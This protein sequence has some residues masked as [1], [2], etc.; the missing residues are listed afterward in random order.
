MRCD[1]VSKWLIWRA[2]QRLIYKKAW[3]VKHKNVYGMYIAI[4][5]N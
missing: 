3:R 1:I 2:F 4:L 5:L